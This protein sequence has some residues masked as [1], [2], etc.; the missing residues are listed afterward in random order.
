MTRAEFL[1]SW[2]DFVFKGEYY[3]C[4]PLAG[5][6]SFRR[7]WRVVTASASYVVMDAPPPETT[8]P[9]VEMAHLL[10][11][12][13]LS[14]PNIIARDLKQGFLLLSDL[15]DHLYLSVLKDASET[16]DG[17]D[18]LYQ[19]A[20]RALVTIHACTPVGLS[21]VLP[22]F[23]C[24][25]MY[26]QLEVFKTW[27]LENH[28]GSQGLWSVNHLFTAW[29][30]LGPLIHHVLQTIVLQPKVLIHR[31]YHSR[32]LMVLE[33]DS[34]GILDFQDALMGPVTYDLVSLLQDCYIAWPRKKILAWAFDFKAMLVKNALLSSST[35][36]AQ[37]VK[38]L[39][40]TGLQR[41]LK[42]L[43][44]FSR[45]HYRD[46]KSGYLADIP[47]LLKYIS[48]TCHRYVELMPLWDFFEHILPV[49]SLSSLS[50][51]T[52]IICAP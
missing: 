12:Q 27:Y 26:E 46:G 33:T 7:Y 22:D 21:G 25:F 29:D 5:D 23:N 11:N 47:M 34:P 17:V 15:G 14:V 35:D 6:A 3:S 39:D 51:E 40:W 49:S 16:P 50:L 42:N 4:T 9:F 28:L 43:G 45:L 13:G 18:A 52:K 36:D 1:V 19:D 37:F 24:A 41:H 8:L 20:L 48:E 30:N 38:W 10:K 44:I 32:N 2:L 31:D